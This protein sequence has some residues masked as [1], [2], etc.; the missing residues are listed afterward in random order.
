MNDE[1]E[2]LRTALIAKADEYDQMKM[3]N[4]D[5]ERRTKTEE[6]HDEF[7]QF[8]RVRFSDFRR[9]ITSLFPLDARHE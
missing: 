9:S 6:R 2:R 3:K 8:Q 1:C 4:L 5:L 7:E